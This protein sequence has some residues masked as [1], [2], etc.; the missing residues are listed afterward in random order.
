MS[1][2]IQACQNNNFNEVK[3]ILE[4][5]EAYANYIDPFGKCPLLETSNFKIIKI[6]VQYRANINHPNTGYNIIIKSYEYKYFKVFIFLIKNKAYLQQK[7]F[8]HSCYNFSISISSTYQND[9]LILINNGFIIN[10][11]RLFH[12][13]KC[14]KFIFEIKERKI[15]HR[16]MCGLG[17][18]LK[19]ILFYL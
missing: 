8:D 7:Y 18:I 4:N 9:S 1:K 10:N 15:S 14:S 13:D 2:L 5:R 17:I 3:K 11:I 6:L 19:I 12:F 16:T